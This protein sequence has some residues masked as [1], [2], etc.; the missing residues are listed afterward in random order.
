MPSRFVLYGG[1]SI[2]GE[3]L[4]F[5]Y[6]HLNVLNDYRNEVGYTKVGIPLSRGAKQ[7]LELVAS[8]PENSIQSLDILFHGS[9]NGLTFREGAN[10]SK[11]LDPKTAL[12]AN[13]YRNFHALMDDV[14]KYPTVKV[15]NQLRIASLDFSKFTKACKIEIHGCSTASTQAFHDNICQMLSELLYDAG[16]TEAVVIGHTTAANPNINGLKDPKQL[17]Y[18][19][20]QRAIYHAG[21]LKMLTYTQKRIEVPEIR[22][23]IKATTLIKKSKK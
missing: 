1:A 17:D 22:E 2:A 13:L 19:H 7:I 5:E 4:A 3:N 20:G 6:A 16:K 15:N 11:N 23:A 10:T 12:N 8:Q 9:P 18:R 14:L 21:Q